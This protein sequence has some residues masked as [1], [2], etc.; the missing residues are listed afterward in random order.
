MNNTTNE[1]VFDAKRHVYTLDGRRM[2]GVTSVLNV[3]SK[4]ALIQ[5]SANL[6]AAKAFTFMANNE[7]AMEISKYEKIDTKI[8]KSIGEK[9]PEYEQARTAHNASRDNAASLGTDI[10]GIIESIV[11]TAIADFG[12]YMY[13]DVH[14]EP[15]V[16]QFV[17]W[18]RE[19]NIKFL[20]SEQKLC[21][22]SLWVAGTMDLLFEKEG[23]IYTGDIKTTGAIWDRTP[24]M[25]CAAYQFMLLEQYPDIK[26][27]G[28]CIIRLDKDGSLEVMY[29]NS[30]LD[31]QGFLAALTLF[32][33]L[34]APISSKQKMIKQA[35]KKKKHG[36]EKNI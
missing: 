16:Q 7:L 17:N 25:Q 13:L 1:L 36:K 10:H 20:M 31:T 19:E 18:A 2:Y 30:E 23:L 29:S 3:I 11:K 21:S 32:K 8:A 27:E 12:G 28:R 6:A 14:L 35:I 15:Q 9:F 24:F 34:E 33:A 4:P 26:V 22:R 5:W